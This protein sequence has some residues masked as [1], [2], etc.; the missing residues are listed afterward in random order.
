[1]KNVAELDDNDNIINIYARL[2]KSKALSE[3]RS[4]RLIT[5][6]TLP[7]GLIQR[8]QAVV[9]KHTRWLKSSYSDL[10]RKLKLDSSSGPIS[11]EISNHLTD[12]QHRIYTLPVIYQHL[13]ENIPIKEFNLF[14]SREDEINK[15]NSAYNN[16]L[17]DN[18]AAS[19]VIGENG[20]G[21]SSLLYYY[22]KTLKSNYQILSFQVSRFYYTE[23]DYYALIGEIFSQDEL[24][25][26]QSIDAFISS[27]KERRIVIIDGL[28]RLF[29]RKVNGFTCLLK[30]LSL[31]V[32]TNHQILWIC[33]VSKYASA[34]LNKTIALSEYFDYSINIDSLSSE[35]IQ[36]IVL[37][38][39]RLSGFQVK[40][41]MENSAEGNPR[42]K[43]L[44]Q[45]EL[46][47]KVF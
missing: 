46:E 4:K 18:F 26:D 25:S 13:F 40:Y 33:S 24:S 6:A 32:S 5:N 22:S 9:S 10:K 31:I 1:M 42:P 8:F 35:Q 19:L 21:K 23:N 27:F 2:L 44:T 11:S 15:L 28:E 45:V 37:K 12:I 29:I 39:N 34:Y 38:R 3:S 16:W 47:D 36:N 30:L 20:S 17:K 7:E 43:K 41:Q 14:L